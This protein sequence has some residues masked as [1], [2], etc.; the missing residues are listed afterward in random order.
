ME[1]LAIPAMALGAL[2]MVSNQKKGSDET[3]METF[4]SGRESL[5][6]INL[7]DRNFRTNEESEPVFGSLGELDY[8][9]QLSAVNQ[10]D[11]PEVY[12]D[13]YFNPM[14]NPLSTKDIMHGDRRYESLTGDK[15]D[16]SYFKHANMT[17]YFGS[18]VRTPLTDGNTNESVLDNMVGAGSQIQNKTEQSPLF[19]PSENLKWS[20]GAPNQTDFIRS[21]MNVSQRMANVKPF[22]EERVGPG[23]NGQGSAGYNSGM[24]ARETWLPKTVDELR[25]ANNPKASHLLLGHEGPAMSHITNLGLLG[26]ME[27]NRP[28][29][30]YETGPERYITTTGLEKGQTLHSIPIERH[31]NRAT[32]TASYTG[33]AGAS[34]PEMYVDGEYM[35]S[36]H[37]DLGPVP[38][39]P[40]NAVG[41]SGAR[42][43]EYGI[44]GK[45]A[46][47][48]NRTITR[49][50]DYFGAVG[51]AFGSVVSP[52]LDMLRPSRRENTIGSLRPYQNPSSRVQNSYLF[53]PADRPAPTLR[54]MTEQSKNH[55]NVNANQRGGAYAVAEHQP[56]FTTRQ[57]TGDFYYSGIAGG[58]EGHKQ[59]RTYDA[60]YAQRNNDIKSSTIE[61]R[62]VPGNMS[63]MQG[64]INMSSKPKDVF[65][66]NN[67]PIAP[68]SM[69][70]QSP[71]VSSMGRLQGSAPLYQTIQMDRN[72]PDILSSLKSN[73]YT[74][75][76]VNGL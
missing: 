26:Q 69:P 67:R 72:A 70:Y 2:Y 40:A 25:V 12:T 27:K 6:N 18:N 31:V 61:G 34:N 49:T 36:R 5:P 23:L 62:M 55:L 20:H 59:V 54:E 44:H 28:E 47:P 50:D 53:N 48:N 13:K 10:Y 38:L 58:G 16:A 37:I 3:T 4:L 39:H 14:R 1:I 8:T 57:Q 52:L 56:T 46:Y 43:G 75:S 42:E 51:G 68:T 19:S 15:V 11:G 73:P 74:L 24:M 32:A 45:M 35:P 9:S 63:L 33:I 71:D 21:R 29:R 17:P 41:R 66:R 22:Q 65:M 30:A 64:D 76:V 60:E 7:P